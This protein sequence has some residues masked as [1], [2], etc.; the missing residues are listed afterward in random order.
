[1]RIE[2]FTDA[3]EAAHNTASI[4]HTEA[5]ASKAPEKQGSTRNYAAE[6][7]GSALLRVKEKNLRA[8]GRRICAPHGL[9]HHE[10]DLLTESFD[11][12]HR[13]GPGV[14][15]SIEAGR[16]PDAE[17]IVRELTHRLRSDVAVRQRRAGMQRVLSTTVFEALGRDGLPK[18]GAHIVAVMPN[19]MA[20]DKLIAGLSR[21]KVPRYCDF[22]R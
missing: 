22:I 4:L 11:Y 5:S 20:R 7:S 9:S 8:P 15:I 12:M 10:R 19:A 21:S 3:V 2:R 16:S 18:F 1:M 17:K 13:R 14:F 6:I